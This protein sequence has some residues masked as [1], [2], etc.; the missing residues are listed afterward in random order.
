[1]IQSPDGHAISLIVKL[2][3]INPNLACDRRYAE[4]I[5][6]CIQNFKPL[7]IQGIMKHKDFDIKELCS[8]ETGC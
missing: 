4:G 5:L 8:L 1:M 2:I 7:K 3:S 6:K